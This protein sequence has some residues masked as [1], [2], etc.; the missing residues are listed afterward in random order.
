MPFEPSG[1]SSELVYTQ[2]PGA[3]GSGGG[4][5]GVH[6]RRGQAAWAT[7]LVRG[8]W[9]RQR[10]ATVQ[11]GSTPTFET[12]PGTP[13]LAAP[14]AGAHSPT[15]IPTGLV[16]VRHDQLWL[17]DNRTARTHQIAGPLG[18]NDIYATSYYGQINWTETYAWHP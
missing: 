10:L 1:T 13:L 6:L 8:W 5:P 2:G 7:R 17:L 16:Y 18:D 15:I 14:G 9:D 3:T 12:T 11:P 4:P